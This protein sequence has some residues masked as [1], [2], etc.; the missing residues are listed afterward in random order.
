MNRK[1]VT[2][3][4]LHCIHV[5]GLSWIAENTDRSFVLRHHGSTVPSRTVT[6][7]ELYHIITGSFK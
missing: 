2:R 1:I 3:K 7:T 5:I 4:R 6:A